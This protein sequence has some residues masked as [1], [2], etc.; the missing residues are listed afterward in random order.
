MDI[1][2]LCC[3]FFSFYFNFWRVL[4]A[5]AHKLVYIYTYT[6]IDVYR[7]SCMCLLIHWKHRQQLQHHDY[8]H[9]CSR[10]RH[11]QQHH[12]HTTTT[13]QQQQQQRQHQQ[14]LFIQIK[15]KSSKKLEKKTSTTAMNWNKLLKNEEKSA[16]SRFISI[17][18]FSFF[19]FIQIFIKI[20]ISTHK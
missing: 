12:L 7:N 20:Y 13:Y 5:R 16:R 19:Y 10:R 15:Y 1:K 8:H 9:R 18:A 17:Y 6:Y 11:H 3:S 2:C 4:K 14:Y